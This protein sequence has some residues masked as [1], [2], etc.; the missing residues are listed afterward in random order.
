MNSTPSSGPRR[1]GFTGLSFFPS[2]A[3]FFFFLKNKKKNPPSYKLLFFFLFFFFFFL[4]KK[5]K[6]PPS[7]RRCYFSC[8]CLV[9]DWSFIAHSALL[10][11]SPAAPAFTPCSQTN[12]MVSPHLR[13][14]HQGNRPSTDFNIHDTNRSLCCVLAASSI[15]SYLL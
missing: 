15:F 3:F 10:P 5:K 6:N 11:V 8:C 1:R 12:S 7:H 13:N 14:S 9:C 2:F 4:Q